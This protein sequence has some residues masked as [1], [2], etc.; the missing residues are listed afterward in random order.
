MRL[1]T[2]FLFPGQGAYLPG[3]L[4]HFPAAY[5]QVGDLMR[6]VDAVCAEYGHR[7]VSEMLLDLAAP[8][9][10]SLLAD[11][12]EVLHL[13]IFT[14]SLACA[15]VCEA[16]GVRPD[17]LVGHSFGEWAALTLA[18]VWT[19]TEAARLICER[20]RVCRQNPPERG[21]LLAVALSSAR[22]SRLASVV[23]DWSLNVAVV[24]GPGQSVL[25]G[26]DA[27]LEQAHAVAVALGVQAVRI[28]A[29]YPYHSPWLRGV[30]EVFG[31]VMQHAPARV[32]RRR[33]Y[34][35]IAAGYLTTVEDVRRVGADHMVRPVDFLAALHRLQ[36]DGVSVFVEC[37]VKDI[38]TR[39]TVDVMPSVVTAAPLARRGGP[40]AARAALAP[41]LAG[42]PHDG[43]QSRPVHSASTQQP[44]VT[45]RSDTAPPAEAAPRDRTESTAP[46]QETGTGR[47][48]EPLPERAE[49]VTALQEHYAEHLGY[50][51]E[52]LTADADLEADLGI[53]SLRQTEMLTSLYGRYGLDV[54]KTPD[55]GRRATLTD[56]ADHLLNM[57][58]AASTTA[59]AP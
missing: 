46:V 47:V 48:A 54:A 22:A 1:R 56:I 3:A 19:P 41:L 37:G 18:G 30:G 24:N 12:P 21:G 55:P 16:E 25:A 57:S 32:P 36:R 50:P 20:D 2:A 28:K 14:A 33:V 7:P 10:E 59:S 43:E 34:S 13:C 15:A 9:I 29:A 40:T 39:L 31:G 53:D 51:R 4:Q 27:A 49:L 26:P 6:Q 17:L 11:N 42:H 45:S 58:R 23:D 38:V 8:R 35:P 52:V 5:P 44:A